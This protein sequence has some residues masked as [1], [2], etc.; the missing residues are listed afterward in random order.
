MNNI[1]ESIHAR[2]RLPLTRVALLVGYEKALLQF[3]RSVLN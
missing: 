1:D 3:A 2:A